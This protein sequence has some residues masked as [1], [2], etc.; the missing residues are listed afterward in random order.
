MLIDYDK[1]QEEDFSTIKDMISES[2][3]LMELSRPVVSA[4]PKEGEVLKV[5]AIEE[6]NTALAV[7]DLVNSFIAWLFFA[8][9][10]GS[11]IGA[12]CISTLICYRNKRQ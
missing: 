1:D 12:F 8:I 11:L 10:G 4:V 3:G 5:S 7:K 6:G 9:I 2:K